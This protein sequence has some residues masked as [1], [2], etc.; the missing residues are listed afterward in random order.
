MTLL[1]LGIQPRKLGQHLGVGVRPLLRRRARREAGALPDGGMRGE[2]LDLLVVGQ[3][4]HERRGARQRVGLARKPFDEARAALEQSRELV[5]A[6]L[7][8]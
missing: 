2:H 1:V 8:R 5:A 6:Q 7:P 4:V 3:L